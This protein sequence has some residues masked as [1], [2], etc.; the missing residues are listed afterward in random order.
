MATGLNQKVESTSFEM[1]EMEVI[2]RF[3][4]FATVPPP[5]DPGVGLES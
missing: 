4:L 2:C 3:G 5:N 1:P